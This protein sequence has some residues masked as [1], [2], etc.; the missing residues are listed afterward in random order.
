M[1][2]LFSFGKPWTYWMAPLITLLAILS[3]LAL[4][5]GYLIKVV[6]AKYPKQ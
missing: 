1:D 2:L 3:V 5:V 4:F 6:A